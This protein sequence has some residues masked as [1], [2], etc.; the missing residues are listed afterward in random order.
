MEASSQMGNPVPGTLCLPTGILYREPSI[1]P[2]VLQPIFFLNQHVPQTSSSV[3]VDLNS[4][5]H[6]F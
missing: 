4:S 2:Y 1:S 3:Y 6:H 5:H